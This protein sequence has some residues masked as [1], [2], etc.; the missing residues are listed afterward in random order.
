MEKVKD[1]KQHTRMEC[2]RVYTRESVLHSFRESG[3]N[4]SDDTIITAMQT[5]MLPYA[6]F[7]LLKP[8]ALHCASHN[9]LYLSK[10]DLAV[11]RILC[12][13]PYF[14][15]HGGKNLLDIKELGYTISEQ[16]KL[17]GDVCVRHKISSTLDVKVSKDMLVCLQVEIESNIR[18]FVKYMQ[19]LCNTTRFGSRNFQQALSTILRDDHYLQHE[20]RFA[21]Y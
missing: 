10:A 21:V 20:N 14:V 4:N 12:D 2:Q 15:L 9:R 18:G 3:T 17:I 1:I 19:N 5:E 16:M 13:W 7:M 8:A 11:G 6:I